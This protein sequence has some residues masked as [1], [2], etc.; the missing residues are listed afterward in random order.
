VIRIDEWPKICLRFE[1]PARFEIHTGKRM[2]ER[3]GRRS[4]A[5]DTGL[6]A[7]GQRDA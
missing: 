6:V 4:D 5:N 3:V 1:V 7:D 2:C